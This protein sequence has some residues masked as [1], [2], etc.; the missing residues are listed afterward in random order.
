MT[1][2]S[3]RI[4]VADDEGFMRKY[5][6]TIL[7][8]LGHEVIAVAETGRELVE[9]C[10]QLQ[11]DLVITDVSMPEMDGLE[12]AVAIYRARPLPII[13][14]SGFHGPELIERTVVAHV[15]AYMVKPIKQSDLEPVITLA[16]RRF[17]QLQKLQDETVSLRDRLQEHEVIDRALAVLMRWARHGKGEALTRLEQMAQDQNLTLAEIA[18]RI[19][20]TDEATSASNENN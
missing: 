16:M 5:M 18:E 1:N 11:P 17:E 13:V 2:R 7:P 12:A 4:A 3:L 6:Q 9:R 10:C 19:V 15:M 14:I 20:T 8:R